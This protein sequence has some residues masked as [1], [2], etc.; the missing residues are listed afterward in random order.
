MKKTVILLILF[1]SIVFCKPG[2]CQDI[3]NRWALGLDIS[4]I[5]PQD[6]E[7]KDTFSYPGR[8]NL[9]FGINNN[10]AIELEVGTYS[11]KSKWDS[12]TRIYTF[13]TNLELRTKPGK[14][15]PY[16]LF[17]IGAAFFS[18]DDLHPTERKDKSASYAYKGGVG[19]EYF[20]TENWAV[21]L[22]A[23]H[24]YANTGGKATL[25]VY[26]YQYSTGLK[27]YF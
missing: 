5:F 21:N 15:V 3:K 25:D 27:Y 14:I 22:E 16:A 1:I 24:F 2:F 19:I 18:Y 9:S 10:L 20:L 7:Y 23:V 6:I 26:S 13:L 11:L 4:Y 17:G 8:I 12:K